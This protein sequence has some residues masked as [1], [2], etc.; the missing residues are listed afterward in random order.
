MPSVS[1][2][3]GSWDHLDPASDL[4]GRVFDRDPAIRYMLCN[5]SD[6]EHQEYLQ[7]YW[8]GLCR[9]AL[10]NGAV[11]SEADDWKSAAVVLPPGKSVDNPLMIIP[12][13]FGFL[14]VLWRIGLSGLIRMLGEYS[15]N[16]NAVKKRALTKQ[17]HYYVFAIGTEYEFQ[18]R[19]FAKALMQSLQ[20]EAWRLEV[21]IWLEATTERSRKLYLSLGFED[22]E[23][24]TIGVGKAAADGTM[25]IGGQGIT[26]WAMVWWPKPCAVKRNA[27]RQMAMSSI[28]DL[29]DLSTSAA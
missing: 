1:I 21:P 7:Q 3:A 11:I 29:D 13:A 25:E 5:L 14:G 2:N 10:L 27:P 23:E 4:L 28:A 6:E 9:T 24:V 15:G 26:L 22:V 17:Q 16:L 8:R 20:D 18:G 12:A 19:G